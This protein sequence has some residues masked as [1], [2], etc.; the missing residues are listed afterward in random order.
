MP[1]NITC[2]AT[3]KVSQ[4]MRKVVMFMLVKTE[5]A[6]KEHVDDPL[7]A[8]HVADAVGEGHG[9][10]EL[11]EGG[12]GEGLVDLLEAAHADAGA[13]HEEDGDED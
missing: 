12:P 5:L 8:A 10:A 7:E 2:R 1:A 13:E 6:H 4:M 9:K 3:T 11:Q